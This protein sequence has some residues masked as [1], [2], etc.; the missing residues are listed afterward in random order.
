[1]PKDSEKAQRAREKKERKI[2]EAQIKSS[3]EKVAEAKIVLES[4]MKA[5]NQP[6]YQ[7]A[8]TILDNAIEL[9]PENCDAFTY[10]GHARRDQLLLDEAIDDYT[11]AIELNANAVAAYEGRATC[12]ELMREYDKAIQ[13]YSTI[14]S[15]HPE[16]D[17]AYNMRGAALLKKRPQGLLLKQ[18]DYAA[19]IS[20][21]KTALR[22]NEN[23]YHARTNL[24]KAHSDQRNYRE[25]IE[26]FTAALRINDN[27][28][29]ANFRRACASI[30]LANEL[31]RE[32]ERYSSQLA[33]KK[34]RLGVPSSNLNGSTGLGTSA[35]SASNTGGATAV[36]SPTSPQSPTSKAAAGKKM[37]LGQRMAIIGEDEAAASNPQEYIN[38]ED[39][40]EA[41]SIERRKCLTS[42]VSDLNKI[43]DKEKKNLEITALVHLANCYFDLGEDQLAAQEYH[44]ALSLIP[45]DEAANNAQA[46]QFL[47]NTISGTV[48][49]GRTFNATMAASLLGST[50]AMG[51]VV[52]AAPLGDTTLLKQVINSKLSQ[53]AARKDT[54]ASA[55]LHASGAASLAGTV[56]SVAV[57]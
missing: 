24:G 1:M 51:S 5:T 38:L 9:H 19:V 22:L 25:A 31:Q 18:A 53:L 49:G 3:N 54:A 8:I 7:K 11:K 35:L 6:N 2:L 36:G 41:A 15:I 52:M 37:F 23:N 13:D 44:D 21:F 20:D 27:Y 14:I 10:R 32:E 46:Q 47:G 56:S 12:F 34:S 33:Q 57:R 4:V 26:C 29:Y 43:I 39:K 55:T 28:K 42:A 45:S 50:V 16:N 48:G 30:A 17:H 40:L